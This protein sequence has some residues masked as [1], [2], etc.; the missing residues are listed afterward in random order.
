VR[1]E[2]RLSKYDPAK[3]DFTGAFTGSDW[4]TYSQVGTEVG[5]RLLTKEE[6]KRVEDVYVE[7]IVRALRE[8]GLQKV[9]VEGIR[10]FD[11]APRATN[12]FRKGQKIDLETASRLIRLSFQDRIEVA[13]SVPR[14]MYLHFGFDFLVY[15][16]L[17]KP[18]P[19]AN[20]FAS[21]KGLF[22]E[23]MAS[24]YRRRTRH[25]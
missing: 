21:E 20:A 22:L 1:Y 10:R 19:L 18:T 8:A 24:P 7:T 11:K 15:F 6:Y 12:K 9:L 2:I 23:K 13:L 17:T 5:G 25:R 4:V 16:G 14:Q 3:R